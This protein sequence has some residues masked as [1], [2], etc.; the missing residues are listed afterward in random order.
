MCL[1]EQDRVWTFLHSGSRGVGNKIAQQHIQVAAAQARGAGTSLPHPDLAYLEEGTEEFDRYIAE[2]RWAQHFA[3]LNRE[4]MM[5]RVL[6]QVSEWAGAPVQEQER[7]NCHHN[8]TSRAPL[9]RRSGS[10][11]GRHRAT[12]GSRD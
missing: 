1:D 9:G 8:F 12:E 10:P 2:L 7:I 11:A 6:R 4:E 3:L 5:D